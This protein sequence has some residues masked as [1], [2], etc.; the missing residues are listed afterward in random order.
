MM[1][2]L[3]EPTTR[4]TRLWAGQAISQ[5]DS[6]ITLLALPLTAA[7]TLHANPGRDGH[8]GRAGATDHRA[9]CDHLGLLLSRPRPARAADESNADE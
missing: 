3:D 9:D 8:R 7:L 1:E 5:F 2:R 4:V 6:Q